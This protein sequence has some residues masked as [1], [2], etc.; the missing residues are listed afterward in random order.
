M[1][2]TLGEPV[3]NTT[4][5]PMTDAADEIERLRSERDAAVAHARAVEMEL[6]AV[7]GQVRR[8]ELI[9]WRRTARRQL[10]KARLDR[11]L[12]RIHRS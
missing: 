10:W 1:E 6:G 5:R 7:R 11:V 9:M 3:P 8:L 12:A 4:G 2:T